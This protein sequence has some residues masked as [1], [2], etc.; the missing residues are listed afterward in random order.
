MVGRRFLD[1]SAVKGLFSAAFAVSFRECRGI[2]P[3]LCLVGA[4]EL[5]LP[6]VT[7][8][9]VRSITYIPY[10]VKIDGTVVERKVSKRPISSQYIETVPCTVYLLH[11]NPSH[12]ESAAFKDEIHR[13]SPPSSI[14]SSEA[15]DFLSSA[16][17]AAWV[18][19]SA[20]FVFRGANRHF[21]THRIH[22]TW[23]IYLHLPYD[24]TIHVAINIEYHGSYVYIYY[25]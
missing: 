18:S 16:W 22:G 5:N 7:V 2:R 15:T 13:W 4:P 14:S 12:G 20:R 3:G 21:D 11:R 10:R 23:C 9:G 8:W 25:I 1:L 6:T 19:L 17:R 24:S